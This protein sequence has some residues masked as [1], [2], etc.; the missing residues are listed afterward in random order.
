MEAK[1]TLEIWIKAK[2]L[3]IQQ[4]SPQSSRWADDRCVTLEKL[5]KFTHPGFR[6]LQATNRIIPDL[7]S[8]GL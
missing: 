5:S 6:V 7:V 3:E 4:Y 8:A 2:Y 1:G